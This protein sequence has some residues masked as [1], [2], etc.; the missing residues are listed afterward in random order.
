MTIRLFLTLVVTKVTVVGINSVVDTVFSS[1]LTLVFDKVTDTDCVV[2]TMLVVG[3]VSVRVV[4]DMAEIVVVTFFRIFT[5]DTLVN[6]S[7]SV[8]VLGRS[9]FLFI[10]VKVDTNVSVSDSVSVAVSVDFLTLM[11]VLVVVADTVT[12]TG[13]VLTLCLI[14]VEVNVISDG[15]TDVTVTGSRVL[16][17]TVVVVSDLVIVDGERVFRLIFVETNVTTADDVCVTVSVCLMRFSLVASNVNGMETVLNKVLV[18]F[19]TIVVT[20]KMVSGIVVVNS[21][22]FNL[23]DVEMDVSESVTVRG[24]SRLRLILVDTVSS[25]T[26]VGTV[27]KLVCFR[28]F[29]VVVVMVVGT[30]TDTISLSVMV[31]YWRLVLVLTNVTVVGTLVTT[32]FI[33]VDTVNEVRRSVSVMVLLD[34]NLCLTL[35]VVKTDVNVIGSVSVRVKY[36]M[37]FLTRV[38]VIVTGFSTVLSVV[39][40]MTSVVVC[41]AVIVDDWVR[42]RCLRRITVET[43]VKVCVSAT[44]TVPALR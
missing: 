9:V 18:L 14:F 19:L 30:I 40:V 31:L 8:T 36:F 26:V 37:T 35:V 17:E 44:V 38:A 33:R 25:V 27:A 6:V 24:G 29:T 10:L 34:P 43:D 3:T 5:V 11:A 21:L 2:V 32:R 7:V 20:D 1:F 39:L 22:C 15:R 28:T 16:V 4:D 42:V 23:V 41:V 13:M 12:D